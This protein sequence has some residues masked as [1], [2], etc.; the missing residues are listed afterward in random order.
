MDP[1]VSIIIP[2]KNS[3]KNLVACIHS[4]KK[5]SYANIE[6]IV[7]DNNSTDA[8]KEIARHENI[9]VI[10]GGNE[11][12]SQR[13]IGVGEAKGEFIAF[14]DSDME[15]EPQLIA[16]CIEIAKNNPLNQAIVLPEESF[17]TTFWAQCKQFE[18]S[19]YENIPWLYAARFFRRTALDTTGLFDERIIGGEDFDLQA[20]MVRTFGSSSIA[21]TKNRIF[22]NEGN[23]MLRELLRKKY[24]YGATMSKYKN[25]PKNKR[26][27]SLQ[28]NPIIRTALFFRSPKKIL[29][30]PLIF[31][32]TCIMK[33]LEFCALGL[34]YI[35]RNTLY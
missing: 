11:R 35:N 1:L 27:V 9:R 17:G 26:Y 13:N 33:W 10:E 21:R 16:E 24:Y 12:S 4:I 6:C 22:H 25:N 30:H 23:L 5:Q 34:G 3:S 19:C 7:V 14:I 29:C 28:A 31:A 32:G 8:T 15:L 2:T 20:R 18:R